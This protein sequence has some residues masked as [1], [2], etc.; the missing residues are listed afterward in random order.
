MAKPLPRLTDQFINSVLYS[1]IHLYY[2]TRKFND[3]LY[4][5]Y[6][7][8]SVIENLEEFTGLHALFLHGN[9]IESIEGLENCTELRMLHIQENSI[10]EI[11]GL[12]TLTQ[13]THLNL[14]DN[15]I[16][17]LSGLKSLVALDSLQLQR[18]CLGN[19]GIADLI[20]LVSVPSITILDI[21]CNQISDLRVLPEILTKLTGL[22]VLYLYSNSVCG[23]IDSYRKRI[24]DSLKALTYLDDR[25]VRTEDRRAAE[26]FVAGGLQAEREAMV[27]LNKEREEERERNHQTFREMIEEEKRR[28]QNNHSMHE[29]V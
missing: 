21:S 14:S 20:E 8:I 17:I 18:N 25:S 10:K 7:G 19:N 6:K 15:F 23:L 24:I 3:R 13:L 5:H 16:E 27:K 28:R 4:L 12:E 26:A 29:N 22:S 1:D 11:T 2:P 9:R